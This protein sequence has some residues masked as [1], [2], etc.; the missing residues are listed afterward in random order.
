METVKCGDTVLIDADRGRVFLEPD[1]AFVA[2]TIRIEPV[3]TGARCLLVSPRGLEVLANAGMM[4]DVEAARQVNADGIG[5]F[6]TEFTFIKAGK[7][8]S[9]S[10]QATY[11]SEIISKMDGKPVTL[12]LLDIGGDK[13]LPFLSQEKEENPMLGVRGSR[14]LLKNRDIFRTQVRA[15]AR[16]SK[17]GPVNVLFPM[18]VDA[19]Q[20]NLLLSET[21]KVLKAGSHGRKNMRFGIMFEVPGACLQAREILRKVDFASIG[22]NDLFQYLFAMDRDNEH[23][24]PEYDPVHPVLWELITLLARQA[25]KARRPLSLCGELAAQPG[26][27][28]RLVRAGI[29]ALS[30]SPRF[31]PAVRNEIARV[32]R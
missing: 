15:L 22:S 12:R 5:L 14:F 16:A 17:A 25:K 20:L 18:V 1:S 21:R 24:T 28:K 7:L 2:K 30:V 13:P 3:D 4:E 11:Y 9:E 32:R 29:T 27:A 10:E 19:R 31:V 23:V 8:L 6:R 26:M